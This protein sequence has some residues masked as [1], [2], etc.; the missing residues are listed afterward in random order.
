MPM[1]TREDRTAQRPAK[2]RERKETKQKVRLAGGG[3]RKKTKKRRI[4]GSR[5]NKKPLPKNKRSSKKE[6]LKKEE[7]GVSEFEGCGE[8]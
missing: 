5:K 2:S 8:V 6:R 4:G 1:R 3:S 7:H